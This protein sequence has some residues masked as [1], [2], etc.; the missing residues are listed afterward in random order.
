MTRRLTGAL[1]LFALASAGCMAIS[2]RAPQSAQEACAVAEAPKASKEPDVI[3]VPT[4]Q[5]VV[6]AMLEVAGVG[7][8]DVVYDLGSGDGRIV[9]AAA[10]KFGIRG[11]GIDIDPRRIVEA[12]QNAE[13]AGVSDKVEFLNQ[14][15]F[16]A[17][18]SDATVISLYLLPDLNLKLRPKL[19]QL[20]PGTRI[21][22]HSFD[23]GDWKPEKVVNVDGR[24]VYFWVVPERQ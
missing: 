14:D 11:V 6:D 19:M 23:M 9:I 16:E 4:P 15:L 1:A 18:F 20:A 2:H 3:F 17:D 8:G 7:P 12:R 21:V 24:V 10:Q 13:A 22:S 5:P